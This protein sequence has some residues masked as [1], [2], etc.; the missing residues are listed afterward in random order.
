MSMDSNLKGVCTYHMKSLQWLQKVGCLK[1]RGIK[2]WFLTMY[3]FFFLRAPFR[4]RNFL[5]KAVLVS[6]VPR[7]SS[8]VLFSWSSA[9]VPPLLLTGCCCCCYCLTVADR[10]I[11]GRIDS[12]TASTVSR[13]TCGWLVVTEDDAGLPGFRNLSQINDAR[14]L[15]S[16]LSRLRARGSFRYSDDDRTRYE[17]WRLHAGAVTRLRRPTT[18]CLARAMLDGRWEGSAR[19]RERERE[20]KGGEN[21]RESEEMEREREKEKETTSARVVLSSPRRPI[22]SRC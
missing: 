5:A 1:N 11:D 2:L 18:V 15:L 7:E 12:P 4:P 10:P 9:M 20:R 22:E 6:P 3:T 8:H 17:E 13:A 21:W 19:E 16:D 14:V